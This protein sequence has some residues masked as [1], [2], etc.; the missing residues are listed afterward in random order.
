[1]PASAP[2][3]NDAASLLAHI[4]SLANE[5]KSAEARAA[6]EEAGLDYDGLK[7]KQEQEGGGPPKFSADA[8]LQRLRDIVALG[9]NAGTN[10]P[11]AEALLAGLRSE[12]EDIAE[13]LAAY[14]RMWDG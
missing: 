14:E 11:E 7:A 12:R 9:K 4:A 13:R 10:F 8:E 3:V 5:G 6:C 2:A 1:M